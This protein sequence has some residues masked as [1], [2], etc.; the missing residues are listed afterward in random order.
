MAAIS[1]SNEQFKKLAEL[2]Y[3]GSWMKNAFHV[4]AEAEYDMAAD[5]VV[6]YLATFAKDHGM[7]A[8]LLPSADPKRSGEM[9]KL[10]ADTIDAYNSDMMFEELI[11]HFAHM[12]FEAK[13]G[14]MPLL[15]GEDPTHS[16]Q[17]EFDTIREE[18]EREFEEHGLARLVINRKGK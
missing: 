11:E 1:F 7:K 9:D 15:D 13:H 8:F 3:L 17:A 4:P 10:T 16:E 14:R 2:A 12:A 18:F 6:D 5:E